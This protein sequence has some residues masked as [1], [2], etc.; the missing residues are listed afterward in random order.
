MKHEP[1]VTEGRS[2][3][4]FRNAAD[5]TWRFFESHYTLAGTAILFWAEFGIY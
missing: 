3:D 5:V 1:F 4:H 2:G